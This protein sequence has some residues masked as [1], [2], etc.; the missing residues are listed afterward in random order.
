MS[1][2][3]SGELLVYLIDGICVAM[4]NGVYKEFAVI[5]ENS[6]FLDD[7]GTEIVS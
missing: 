4:Y 7:K 5:L 6:C 2:Q 1:T 3:W